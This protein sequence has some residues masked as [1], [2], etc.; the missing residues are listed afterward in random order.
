[1]PT[2]FS[3]SELFSFLQ[4]V[5][6]VTNYCKRPIS[7]IFPANQEEVMSR[8]MEKQTV[9][10]CL[11][12]EQ[13]L[14]LGDIVKSTRACWIWD[15]YSQLIFN[16]HSW[17]LRKLRTMCQLIPRFSSTICRN[18]RW[19]Y[20]GNNDPLGLL[21]FGTLRSSLTLICISAQVVQ[22]AGKN[23][24]LFATFTSTKAK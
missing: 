18:V 11:A 16:A 21:D 8:S 12:C 5:D 23:L 2:K 24:N 14:H 6:H 20:F 3:K 1:M 9:D 10:R 22:R 7:L 19:N 15:D 17:N 4:K 13:A